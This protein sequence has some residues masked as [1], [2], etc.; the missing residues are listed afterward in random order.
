MTPG[1]IASRLAELC[2][3]EQFEPAG[4]LPAGCR[5]AHLAR[6]RE[7]PIFT[8]QRALGSVLSP[9][10]ATMWPKLV[11]AIHGKMRIRCLRLDMH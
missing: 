2:P 5:P 10:L 11:R 8:M 4:A 7:R 6:S 9:G 3:Q 1:Q